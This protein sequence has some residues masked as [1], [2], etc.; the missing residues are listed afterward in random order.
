MLY[1][2]DVTNHCKVDWYEY[3]EYLSI[4]L[5]L[6]M[7]QALKLDELDEQNLFS[8]LSNTFSRNFRL[9]LHSRVSTLLD[10]GGLFTCFQHY[11]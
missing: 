10:Q 3:G 4:F 2:E 5:Y 1:K 7:E 6:A 9:E 11:V 8:N